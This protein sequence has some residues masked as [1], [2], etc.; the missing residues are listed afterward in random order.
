MFLFYVLSFFKKGDTIQGG[1]LFKEIRYS[2]F[3]S[4][5]VEDSSH[6]D[7]TLAA[8]DFRVPGNK[9]CYSKFSMKRTV[10]ASISVTTALLASGRRAYELKIEIF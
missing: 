2:S 9:L 5:K 3:F 4:H 8:D 1:T 6:F 7:P 10:K